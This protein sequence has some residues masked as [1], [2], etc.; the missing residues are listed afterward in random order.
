MKNF[1]MGIAW[2]GVILCLATGF[3]TIVGAVLEH[4]GVCLK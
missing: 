3:W 4:V 2:G 1:T